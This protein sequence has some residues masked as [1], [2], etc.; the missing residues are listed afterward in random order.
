MEPTT[1]Q[2]PA[3]LKEKL[4]L[5]MELTDVQKSLSAQLKKLM[6]EILEELEPEEEEATSERIYLEH[7]GSIYLVE[8]DDDR[9]VSEAPPDKLV[10][11][12]LTSIQ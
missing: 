8:V 10:I 7:D 12:P 3:T 2:E 6:D 1:L 5:F 4:I 11:T 9:Y